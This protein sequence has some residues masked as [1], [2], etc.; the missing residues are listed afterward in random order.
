M[1]YKQVRFYNHRMRLKTSLKPFPS[2][3]DNVQTNEETISTNDL[4]ITIANAVETIPVKI[5][6]TPNRAKRGGK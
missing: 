5:V 1:P 6:Q 3:D 4:P 2:I